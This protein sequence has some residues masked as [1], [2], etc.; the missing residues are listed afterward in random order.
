MPS[1]P[2]KFGQNKSGMSKPCNWS[3]RESRQARGYGRD[4]D[5][6]RAIVLIEEPL[7][8]ECQKHGRVCATVVADHI[9]PKAEGGDD[10]R[11]N[12][13]GLCDPCHKAKT[14][15]EAARARKR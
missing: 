5:R 12:Y 9:K 2:P 13:Q 6:M 3:K 1:R 14:A 8:R 10:E 11:E 7:C 4:H 15:Q